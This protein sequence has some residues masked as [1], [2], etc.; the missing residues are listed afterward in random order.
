MDQVSLNSPF[1]VVV[2][3]AHTPDALKNTLYTAGKLTSGRVIAVFG[4]GGDRDR[5]KR[6]VMGEMVAKNA[7]F[8]IVTSDNPRSEKPSDIIDD[9][10]DGIPTDF[11]IEIIEDRSSAIKRAL[12][13]ARE[14][15]SII[16]AGKGHET[17]Q[18]VLGEKKHFDDRE[19]VVHQWN[20]IQ[21]CK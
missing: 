2:D 17:Y 18:E 14:N 13:F 11:P 8:A 5:T 19:T 20:R 15:D 9:I 1:S 10:C 16:V 21:E 3:Y 6:P 12:Q 4:A 7:D